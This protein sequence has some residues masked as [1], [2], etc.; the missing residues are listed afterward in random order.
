MPVISVTMKLE[1]EV[2]TARKSINT[3]TVYKNNS[4]I[5]EKMYNV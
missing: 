1:P 2:I 4:E 5:G 3:S